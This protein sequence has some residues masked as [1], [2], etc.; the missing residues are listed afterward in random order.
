MS[1]PLPTPRLPDPSTVPS[2]A[3]GIVGTGIAR[4]F[5]RAVAETTR[6]RVVAVTARDEAKTTAFAQEFGIATVHPSVDALVA[7]PQIDVVYIATPHPLHREQALAAIAA[8]KHVLIEKPIA[9]SASEAREITSAGVAAGVLVMEAMWTRYLPQA[10]LI[11]RVLAEGIIGDV[12]LV[13]A[14]F[15][16]IASYDPANRLW[17]PELG[18]GALLDAG[19]YPISFASSILGTP[20]RVETAGDLGP[21]GVDTRADLLLV[22]RGGRALVST[23][24]TSQLPSVAAV[25][26]SEGGIKI[27]APFFGPS[28]VTVTRGAAW[29]GEKA[30]F[31]DEQ[32]AQSGGGIGLQATA[33]A[34]FV[35]EGRLES[36]VH[37]HSEIVDVMHTIDLARSAVAA[38]ATV[39]PN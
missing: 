29:D 21:G 32:L 28:P 18:G 11:R 7:D 2:L 13:T 36:P 38:G 17:A 8:G 20:S 6:Q 35:A 5:V 30:I 31:A 12:H 26:G 16:F 4:S 39:S 33:L 15:G 10:D 19:V 27:G 24:I 34:S 14:D 23:S 25:S 3:W 1:L 22:A 9:M 37:P